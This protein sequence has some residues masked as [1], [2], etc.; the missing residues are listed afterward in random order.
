MIYPLTAARSPRYC[1]DMQPIY[2]A[3]QLLPEFLRLQ[4]QAAAS[5]EAAKATGKRV[6]FW[7]NRLA[8]RNQQVAE[9]QARAEAEAKA[10]D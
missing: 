7:E 4:A 6:K 9:W 5:L 3:A 8:M 2:T 10:K 1:P